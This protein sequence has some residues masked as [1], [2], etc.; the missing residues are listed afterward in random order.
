M[1]FRALNFSS[2]YISHY[3]LSSDYRTEHAQLCAKMKVGSGYCQ[4]SP[5]AQSCIALERGGLGNA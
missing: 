1:V 5:H 4:Q 2:I 3:N